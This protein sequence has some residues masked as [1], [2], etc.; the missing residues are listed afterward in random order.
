LQTRLELAS[1]GGPG[2]GSGGH[3]ARS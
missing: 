2:H 3:Y 1:R